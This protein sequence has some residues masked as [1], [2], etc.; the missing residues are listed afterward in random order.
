MRPLKC[1]ALKP[2]CWWNGHEPTVGTVYAQYRGKRVPCV[3]CARCH[4]LFE[5]HL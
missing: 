1:F 5:V 3:M 4:M 2:L